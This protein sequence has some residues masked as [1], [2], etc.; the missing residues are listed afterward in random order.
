MHVEAHVLQFSSTGACHLG[1]SGTPDF[2][3]AASSEPV[4]LRFAASTIGATP[5]LVIGLRRLGAGID[6]LLPAVDCAGL[7]PEPT[8]L[9]IHCSDQTVQPVVVPWDNDRFGAFVDLIFQMREQLPG[10]P[11]WTALAEAFA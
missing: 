5:A 2:L 10:H 4:T 3:M 6:L 11:V 1:V 7:L 8:D 9:V